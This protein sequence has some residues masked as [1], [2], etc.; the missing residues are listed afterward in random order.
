MGA[1]LGLFTPRLRRNISAS[2]LAIGF[3]AGS[4]L[5]GAAAQSCV[6]ETQEARAA[7]VPDARS[8]MLDDGRTLRVAGIESFALLAGEADEAEEAL[9]DR[10]TAIVSGMPLRVQLTSV[11]PDR[12]GRLAALIASLDGATVQETLAREGLAI[13]FSTDAPLPCFD[14]ILAAEEEARREVRGFWTRGTLPE[15]RPWALQPLVGRFAIFEGVV[16][17]VGNRRATTY[18]NFGTW[19]QE[20]VTVEIAAEDRDRFG[21]EAPL[22]ALMGQRVRIRG[23]LED[24]AGP[25]VAV[26]SPMQIEVLGG[27]AVGNGEVP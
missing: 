23:F 5:S 27:T 17:S 11:D 1:L 2:A 9:R 4:W 8:I 26:Q 25:M 12:Y 15:A 13:A 24:K 21:G 22:A 3:V 16:I 7:A 10:L 20:D 14:R 19:W 6:G 18:L